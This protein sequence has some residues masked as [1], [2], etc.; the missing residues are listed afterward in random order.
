MLHYITEVA[1]S[2]YTSHNRKLHIKKESQI[3]V[4]ICMIKIP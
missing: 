1:S 4:P 2:A 3:S